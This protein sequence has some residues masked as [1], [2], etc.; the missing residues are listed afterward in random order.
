[1]AE[2]VAQLVSAYITLTTLIILPWIRNPAP[3]KPGTVVT[4]TYNPSIWELETGGPE[5]QYM[6]KFEDSL[7]YI[8]YCLNTPQMI[9][10]LLLLK[11]YL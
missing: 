1:M 2:D 11:E 8:R 6:V 9:I 10:Q 3:Y 7:G 4:Y 5:V